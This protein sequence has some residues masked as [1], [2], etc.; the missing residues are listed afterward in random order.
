MT[1][2]AGP[3]SAES[4]EQLFQTAKELKAIGISTIRAGVWKPRT[5]PNNFEG[6]GKV[7]LDWISDVKKELGVKFITE[8]GSAQ[9]VEELLKSGIDEIWI[10]ARTTVNPF[11]VQ[12]IAN[13]LKGVDIP[14]WIKNPV[15]PDLKLWIGAF[16]RVKNVGIKQLGLI[17]RG[18]SS[19]AE[20]TYRNE[21][22]WRIPLEFKALFPEIPLICDPSH[23]SGKRDLIFDVSQRAL[24]LNY[25]GLMIETHI[26]PDKALSDAKQQITPTRLKEILD[27]LQLRQKITDK[28]EEYFDNLRQK[29]DKIDREIVEAL[30]ARKNI[31]HDMGQFK[32]DHNIALFQLERWMEINSTRNDWAKNLGI[33]Q[34]MVNEIFQIIHDNSLR[35][36]AEI[37]DENN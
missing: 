6:M 21:P 11:L 8:A 22:I 33:D 12:E 35:I 10:G 36:Q 27:S 15:N 16:E 20:S 26:S 13:A 2:I 34:I 28:T 5:R 37:F 30:L 23:I 17:H 9:H 18:F 7:A 3:C 25:D 31:I 24:D 32:K 4:P 14:V 1:I 19:Y 29:I